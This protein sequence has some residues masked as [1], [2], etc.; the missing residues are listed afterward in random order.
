MNAEKLRKIYRQYNQKK[1]VRPDPLQF[2]YDY[3]ETRDREIVGLVASALAYGR[4]TQILDSVEKA[5]RPL[6]PSPY[7]TLMENEISHRH[8]RGKLHTFRHRFASGADIIEMLDGIRKVLQQFGS[9]NAAFLE[10]LA[11]SHKNVLPA[12]TTFASSLNCAGNHLIPQPEKG[13][14]CKRLNLFLR[15]MVR[16]DAVDPGGWKGVAP[17]QLI[18][19]LD[20]HMARYGQKHQLTRRKTVD[21]K[22]ALEITEAFVQIEPEDP[23]KFDF[24]LTRLGIRKDLA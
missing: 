5:L 16:K 18:V 9:L 19:P 17:S 13:S 21:M 10:T 15:W 22:M 12:L 23:V 7:R 2:L 1:F 20:T 8:W 3:P 24:A 11:T 14:A 4:V 6:G